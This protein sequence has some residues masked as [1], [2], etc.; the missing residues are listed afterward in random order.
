MPRKRAATSCS[1][2]VTLASPQWITQKSPLSRKRHQP[3]GG[4]AVGET[5]ATAG[6][7]TCAGAAG[8]LADAGDGD[9]GAFPGD[10][11]DGALGPDGDFP[12]LGPDGPDGPLLGPD[13][14]LPGAPGA[15]A[16]AITDPPDNATISVAAMRA[17]TVQS[18]GS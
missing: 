15:V 7:V 10:A 8:D 3:P 4:A 16:R 18:S 2:Y 1:R 11:G 14:P 17:F 13:G 9:D 5:E 12:L 6:A